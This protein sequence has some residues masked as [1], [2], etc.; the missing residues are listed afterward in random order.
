MQIAKYYKLPIIAS[1]INAFKPFQLDKTVYLTNFLN[2]N[3][4]LD[5]IFS[6]NLTLN[7]FENNDEW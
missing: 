3:E 7:D 6:K 5:I 1:S 4:I 2:H